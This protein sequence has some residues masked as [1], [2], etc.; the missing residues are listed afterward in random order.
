MLKTKSISIK[1]TNMIILV[2][3]IIPGLLLLLFLNGYLEKKI[4][5]ELL[6]SHCKANAFYIQKA[7]TPYLLTGNYYTAN[8]LID[9]IKDENKIKT[10]TVV[11]REMNKLIPIG[12]PDKYSINYTESNSFKLFNDEY[13]CRAKISSDDQIFGFIEFTAGIDE[14]A[15]EIRQSRIYSFIL[16]IIF[17]IIVII[18]FIIF[19]RKLLSPIFN[20]I[21]HIQKKKGKTIPLDKAIFYEFRMLFEQYN[22]MIESNEQFKEELS[23]KTKL[24]AIGQ[25]T[26]LLA[27]D[28][29]KPFSQI[30]TVLEMFDDFSKNPSLLNKSRFDIKA[31]IKTVET[32]LS[33]IMDFSREVKLETKPESIADLLAFSLHQA[34]L[35][36]KDAN[37]SFKYSIKNKLKPLIDK[38]RFERVLSNIITNGI[39]AIIFMAKRKDGTF[40][41]STLDKRMEQNTNFELVI[42]NNG[43]LFDK[44]DLNNVFQTF[45]TKGKKRGTGLGLASAQKI[46]Q[47]HGG[48]I[49]ARN[50]SDSMGVEF[51]ISIPT[52]TEK[53][54]SKP[55]LLPSCI[56]DMLFSDIKSDETEIDLLINELTATNKTIKVI[57][58]EDEALYRASIRNI[59]GHNEALHRLLT[60]YDVQTV[61]EAI[62]VAKSENVNF[63]IVDI[64]LN[65]ENSG[66]DFLEYVKQEGLG[67]S[68]MVHSNRYLLEDKE[69][70]LS[71]GAKAVI[72][73]PLKLEQLVY[74]LAG[75]QL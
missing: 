32:M 71:L 46:V 15:I 3:V 68:S 73:K 47:L 74:F 13:V 19:N 52:S 50:S 57:L 56:N 66:F 59:I 18:V 16:F 14:T 23:K 6:Y 33:D 17:M 60:L 28:V 62:N 40:W 36:H 4:Y 75:K 22:K 64:D 5:Y 7:I 27:H 61:D 26:S 42:K 51:I 69:R 29:R 10:L 49:A 11:D 24:A 54:A 21:S 48:S 39:E 38:E 12:K 72:P 37:I 43:P 53:D 35:G 45:F 31:S 41:I 2:S 30:D 34:A 70:S 63:A 1:A 65:D 67:I 20:L 9:S 25:T 55:N 8:T 58:L 44:D